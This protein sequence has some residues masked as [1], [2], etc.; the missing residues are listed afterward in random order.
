MHEPSHELT[1]PFR[2]NEEG[3]RQAR[4]FAA[5]LSLSRLHLAAREAGITTWLKEADRYTLKR[6]GAE[7]NQA[8]QLE[9]A[10]PFTEATR[11]AMG[12]SGSVD[13]RHTGW[14]LGIGDGE[15]GE[16]YDTGVTLVSY[17]KT[18]DGKTIQLP[19][20]VAIPSHNYPVALTRPDRVKLRIGERQLA[21]P[22]FFD[23]DSAQQFLLMG[24]RFLDLISSGQ[25]TV[26]QEEPKGIKKLLGKR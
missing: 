5:G 20:D 8:L 22:G 7:A 12:Y 9:F 17:H 2:I 19:L 16:R 14:S 15:T 10:S 4:E 13:T 23:G 3:R 1:P 24:G 21:S 26:L 25:A 6:L 18:A 11:Q